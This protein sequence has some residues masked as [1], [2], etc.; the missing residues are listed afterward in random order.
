M[1][2]TAI[3]SPT[4]N[5]PALT[6]RKAMI[7]TAAAPLAMTGSSAIA[8]TT[9]SVDPALTALRI[10]TDAEVAYNA[11]YEAADNA[12]PAQFVKV[13]LAF[14]GE[15]TAHTNEEIDR[16]IE[17]QE[18]DARFHRADW[19]DPTP[20]LI[21]NK[22]Y[23]TA[24]PYEPNAAALKNELADRKRKSV[25]AYEAAGFEGA[26]AAFRAAQQAL[27]DTRATTVAG[28]VAKLRFSVG[29][30]AKE[31]ANDAERGL[32]L[33]AIADAERLAAEG[34]AMTAPTTPIS[35][36]DRLDDLI[37]FTVETGISLDLTEAITRG[38]DNENHDRVLSNLRQNVRP[39]F[40]VFI[41]EPQA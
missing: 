27:I 21:A 26:Q 12:E 11:A 14:G 15:E 25:E 4:A 3:P 22:Q 16:I 10:A 32:I 5:S 13:P 31:Y 35:D 2:T 38:L 17:A 8:S 29:E 36:D 40:V 9:Q 33:S 7:A 37:A 41:E 1:A 34:L 18:F 6:R 20:D 28:I 30:D 19:I 24:N 39:N 23:I